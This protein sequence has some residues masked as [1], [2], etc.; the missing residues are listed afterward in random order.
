MSSREDGIMCWNGD[1]APVNAA[2]VGPNEVDRLGESLG[3]AG[4]KRP[5][6]VDCGTPYKRPMSS[7]GLRLV[8]LMMMMD[9]L[10]HK[11]STTF[12]AVVKQ[13]PSTASMGRKQLYPPE[14]E[15]NV[16]Y[17]TALSTV[18]AL[19]YKWK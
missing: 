12:C 4:G 9:D 7:S 17:S 18:R 19:A 14:K 15:K 8:E 3:A 10:Y 6:T 11:S 13:V 2:Y 5:R 16:S 1:P